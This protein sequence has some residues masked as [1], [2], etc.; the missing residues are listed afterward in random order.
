MSE[1]EPVPGEVCRN[2]LPLGGLHTCAGV[3]FYRSYPN[4]YELPSYGIIYAT[5]RL[6]L[7]LLL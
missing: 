4:N 1:W 6:F 3:G 2:P 5:V 7:R